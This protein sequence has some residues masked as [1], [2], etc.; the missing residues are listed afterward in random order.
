VSCGYKQGETR[1][2]LPAMANCVLVHCSLGME[3]ICRERDLKD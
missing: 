3:K 1:S 2:G